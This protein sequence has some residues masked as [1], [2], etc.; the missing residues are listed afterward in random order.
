MATILRDGK[1]ST[2]HKIPERFLVNESKAVEEILRQ[3]VRHALLI[4]KR[5]G[6]PV[7]AW[8]DGRVVLVPAE[9]IPVE[10][11]IDFQKD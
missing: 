10:D 2:Q 4:H 8:K 5:V 9:E 3:A 1:M 6:N 11:T 7:A